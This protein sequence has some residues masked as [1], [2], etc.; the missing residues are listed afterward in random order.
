MQDEGVE[1]LNA[2]TMRVSIRGVHNAGHR[3]S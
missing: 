3:R 2:R 1:L